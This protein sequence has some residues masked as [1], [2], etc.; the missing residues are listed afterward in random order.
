M[1]VMLKK[2]VSKARKNTKSKRIELEYKYIRLQVR[3]E[4]KNK[5]E[6]DK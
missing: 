4:S 1:W 3:A 5:K 6:A 2:L